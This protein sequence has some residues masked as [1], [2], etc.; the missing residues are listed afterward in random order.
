MFTRLLTIPRL[1]VL[2]VR[3]RL[4]GPDSGRLRLCVVGV[5]LAVALMIVLTGVSI[6][7]ASQSTV[8]SDEVDFWIMPEGADEGSAVLPGEGTSLGSVHE[9]TAD[10]S[11]DDRV[12]YVTPVLIE[13]VGLVHEETDQRG[14]ILVMGV[15]PT[16]DRTVNGIPLDGLDQSYG[17]YNDGGYDGTWSGGVVATD[18]TIDVLELDTDRDG[19]GDVI[20]ERL[21]AHGDGGTYNLTIVAGTDA[22]ITSGVGEVPTVVLP[23]AEAQRLTG[24][25]ENDQA[26]QILVSTNDRAVRSDLEGVYPGTSVVSRAGL[27]G[28]ELTA[29]SLPLAMAVSSFLVSVVVG[30]LFVATMMGLELTANRRMLA[31]L[32]AI[33]FS[34]RSRSFLIFAETITIAAIGG[35]FGTVLGVG[36]IVALN[37]LVV[38]RLGVSVAQ[39]E[40]ALVGYGVAVAIVIGILAAPYPVWL[41]RR[42]DTLEVLS[43]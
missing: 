18:A 20:G 37:R 28:A 33:G 40:P 17:Y 11:A 4:M 39:F 23:L 14:Y 10:L 2:R 41:A 42:Q 30:V 16:T 34:S 6:G 5:A 19:S 29:S 26:D 27:T 12:D 43:T 1:A 36:G 3:G 22:G 25:V 7:L 35:V 9:V 24:H 32:D 15:I 13:P 38:D 31:T 8:Q 21:T